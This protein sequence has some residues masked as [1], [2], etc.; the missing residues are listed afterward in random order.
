MPARKRPYAEG[1]L[2]AVPLPD[3]GYGVGLAART[4]KTAAILGY[5]FDRRF[6]QPPTTRELADLS[7]DNVIIGLM[8]GSWPVIGPLPGWRRENWPSPD[9]GR[10]QHSLGPDPCIYFRVQY[11]DNDPAVWLGEIRISGDEFERLP[12]DGGAGHGWIEERLSA[13]LMKQRQAGGKS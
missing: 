13:L 7:H 10:P 4:S 12:E 1:D 11:D 6:H 2:F 8:N 5:F 9:F 3:G